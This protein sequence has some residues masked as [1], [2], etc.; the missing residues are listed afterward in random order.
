MKKGID[1]T[2]ISVVY[3]CH[4]GNG[5]FMMAKR[6][7]ECRDEHG[8]W[9]IGGGGLEFGHTVIDTLRKEIKEEY[10][11]DV[12]EYEFLGYRD[13]HREHDG[14]KTHWLALD[15]KVLID[16][17]IVKNGEPHKFDEIKW[18]QLSNIPQNTHSQFP[19]FLNLYKDKL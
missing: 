9:D 13:V 8:R 15:F 14:Q 5:N 17:S 11:S 12:I 16:R 2:G 19:N 1:Y 4:D 10:C 7:K 3:F 18:Y 6:S